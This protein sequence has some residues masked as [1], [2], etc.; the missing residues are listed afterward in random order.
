M[1]C[2]KTVH[3]HYSII[4][5]PLSAEFSQWG[6]LVFLCLGDMASGRNVHCN[7]MLH[8]SGSPSFPPRPSPSLCFSTLTSQRAAGSYAP[9]WF[10]WTFAQMTQMWLDGHGRDLC[11]YWHQKSKV[12][13]LK[14]LQPYL[15]QVSKMHIQVQA[16]HPFRKQ[17]ADLYANKLHISTSAPRCA[18][19]SYYLIISQFNSF[20][21]AT[22]KHLNQCVTL[23][24]IF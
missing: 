12:F 4:D 9:T 24:H 22:I 2:Y 17:K 19:L 7:L 1:Q 16:M 8:P 13:M 15:L 21:P 11:H 23:M 14:M 5:L 6:R 10:Q 3:Q 18:H 20:Y